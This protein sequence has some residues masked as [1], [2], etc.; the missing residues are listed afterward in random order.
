M[1]LRTVE[2][3]QREDDGD[4]TQDQPDHCNGDPRD[5]ADARLFAL[6][7]APLLFLLGFAFHNAV[8]DGGISGAFHAAGHANVE[9]GDHVDIVAGTHVIYGEFQRA[10][11]VSLR[12]R[13]A[14]RMQPSPRIIGVNAFGEGDGASDF[15][16]GNLI[17]HAERLPLE[18][19]HVLIGG[20]HALH[21]HGHVEFQAACRCDGGNVPPNFDLLGTIVGIAGNKTVFCRI[22]RLRIAVTLRNIGDIPLLRMFSIPFVGAVAAWD[23]D[24]ALLVGFPRC[25]IAH[26]DIGDIGQIA[27]LQRVLLVQLLPWMI[28]VVV[29]AVGEFH[30]DMLGDLQIAI[31]LH[32]H[33]VV[34]RFV[35]Q[36]G[37]TVVQYHEQQQGRYNT[38]GNND[39]NTEAAHRS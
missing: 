38:N 27:F 10:V 6:L 8:F 3:A 26:A 23:C 25:Y 11:L 37:P 5:Q 21:S 15:A 20:G 12:F 19:G 22:E 9:H 13:R 32:L 14:F 31:A 2:A 30:V 34:E 28:A 4:H 33:I 16:D 24:I 1:I 18:R 39:C 7:V 17:A 29:A 36:I 35:A